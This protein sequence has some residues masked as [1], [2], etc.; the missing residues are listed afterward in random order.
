MDKKLCALLLGLLLALSCAA[1]GTEKEATIDITLNGCADGEGLLSVTETDENGNAVTNEY[2]LVGLLAVPGETLAETLARLDFADLTPLR[3][4]DTPEGWMEY[5]ETV[6][7]DEDGFETCEYALVSDRIYSTEEL[8]AMK[9]ERNANYVVKWAGIPAEDYFDP[10]V[11]YPEEDTSGGIFAFSANGGLMN[12][13]EADGREYDA[14]AYTYWLEGGEALND[15]MGTESWAALLETEKE[16]ATFTGWT[17]YEADSFFW[18]DEETEEDGYTRFLYSE[19]DAN[20]QYLLLENAVC[21]RDNAS[22]EELCGFT[23]TDKSYFAVANW[24]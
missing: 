22:T 15:I 3:E 12:F 21:I 14:P 11:W 23:V 19:Q 1:C 16:G 10:D 5:T 4:G 18:S 6:T 17:V 20:A 9:A 8:L 2:D 24:N 13:H 7:T